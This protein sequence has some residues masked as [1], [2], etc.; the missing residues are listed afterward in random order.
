MDTLPEDFISAM[1]TAI[2]RSDRGTAQLLSIQAVEHY[3]DHKELKKYACVL[4][5]P[6]VTVNQRPPERDTQVNQD[7]IKENRTQYRGQWV[8]LHNGHL[9]A[10]ARK[11]DEFIDQLSD[12]KDVFL[13][14]IY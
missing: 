3:P 2:E 13:T 1:R 11:V 8:A 6:R 7:W 10:S 14:A 12:T 9:L 5:P 4:A